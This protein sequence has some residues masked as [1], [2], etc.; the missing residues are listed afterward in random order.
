MIPV[1]FKVRGLSPLLMHNG[2]MANP[3]DPFAKRM[4]EVTG[5]KKKTD[6]DHRLMAEIEYLGSLYVDHNQRPCLPSELIEATLINGAKASKNGKEAKKGLMVVD[7][8]PLE[9]AGPKTPGDLFKDENF[10]D[11][12]MVKVGTARVCRTRPCFHNWEAEFVV[13]YDPDI[14]NERDV[15]SFVQEA[16]R[17]VGFGDNRPKYGRF[18]VVESAA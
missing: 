2:R 17:S 13:Q 14:L 4:K 12:R 7:H 6:D 3:L 1:R 16:G 11:Q 15:A 18:E 10:V 9:Y 8:A 5:K